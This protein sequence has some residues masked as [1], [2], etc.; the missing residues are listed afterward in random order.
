[1]SDP[2]ESAV[3][4]LLP[5]QFDGHTAFFSMQAKMTSFSHF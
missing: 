1:V 4:G 2:M 5:E 3:P